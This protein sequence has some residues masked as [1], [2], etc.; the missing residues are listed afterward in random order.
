MLY[1]F[2]GIAP[3]VDPSAYVSPSAEVIGDVAIGPR[4]YIG[5][6]AVIRGDAAR[7]E[8][9]EETAV[10][11]GVI[12]H[13]GGGAVRLCRIGRRVTIGHGAIVHAS[14]IGQEASIGM[15]AI[16][17]LNCE[18]GEGSI[19]AEAA[20]VPRGRTVEAGTLVAGAPARPLRALEDRDRES[21]RRTKDWYVQM[22]ARCLG[23]GGIAA[24]DTEG[25]RHEA[26][27]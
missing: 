19:V 3:Q 5:P 17:S 8:I 2:E 26:L 15:G 6:G 4:S 24:L 27:E 14:L 18:I 22:A 13:A 21:W 9:G 25:D 20:M 12:I 11:D 10:E 23:A 7:I 1:S 16:L